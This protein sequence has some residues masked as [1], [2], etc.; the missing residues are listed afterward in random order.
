MASAEYGPTGHRLGEPGQPER[1]CQSTPTGWNDVRRQPLVVDIEGG[2]EAVMGSGADAI[3]V[4]FG[5]VWNS[6]DLDALDRVFTSEVLVHTSP[7]TQSRGS[8]VF[9]DVIASWRQ[10]FSGL[11]HDIDDLVEVPGQVIVRWHG[12]GTHTGDFLGIAPTGRPMSY[13]GMTWCRLSDGLIA[14]AWVAANVDEM[15]ASLT[16]EA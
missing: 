7:D 11:H 9:R 1:L 12:S 6:G 13:G 14:E 3:G 16:A 10:A 4:L 15:V 2:T 5:E 8:A